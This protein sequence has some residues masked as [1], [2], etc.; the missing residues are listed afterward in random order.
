MPAWQA[1]VCYVPKVIAATWRHMAADLQLPKRRYLHRA[2]NQER[3]LL[4]TVIAGLLYQDRF[5]FL[6]YILIPWS[7]AQWFLIAVNLPQH[8]GCDDA[9][10]WLHSRNVTGAWSNWWFLN[11]GYHTAHHLRPGLHW[12]ELAAWHDCHVSPRLAGRLEH[13]TLTGFWRAWWT[14]REKTS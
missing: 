2:V 9:S 10:D 4:W 12:S 11:N 3:L 14:S 5:A 13:R 1:L 6:I 8:D 7:F